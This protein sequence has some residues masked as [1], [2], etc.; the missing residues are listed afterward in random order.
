MA[1]GDPGYAERKGNKTKAPKVAERVSV[2]RAEN[3]GFIVSCSHPPSTGKG[4]A[5]SWEPDKEYAFSN[6]DE[7]KAF[8]DKAFDLGVK[9][10]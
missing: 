4:G 10:E 1:A 2:K 5:V 8:V 6:A 9:K 7:M 3:G